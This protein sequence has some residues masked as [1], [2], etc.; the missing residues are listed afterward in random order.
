FWGMDIDRTAVVSLKARLDHTYPQGVHIGSYTYVTF[1]ACILA[2]DMCRNIRAHT[3]IGAN[4]S[5]GTG[6]IVLPGVTIGDGSV[7]AA[8]AVV[9]KDVPSGVIVAGN[10]AKI[11]KSGISV[12]CF[13]VL[14]EEAGVAGRTG[15]QIGPVPI[16]NYG[17]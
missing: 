17:N 14:R 7:V 4:C 2:H 12:G 6:A 9:T 1:G 16:D 15:S 8:G 10:P 11:I 5:I 13:G 3:R